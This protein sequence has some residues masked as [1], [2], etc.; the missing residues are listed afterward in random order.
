MALA[1]SVPGVS[2]GT[3][4]FILGFYEKFIESLRN[5]FVRHKGLRDEAFIYL[6]KLGIG[7]VIGFLSSVMVLSA[8]FEKNI[9]FMSSLFLGLSFAAIPFIIKAE[10]EMIV[11]KYWNL[12]FTLLGFL[13]VAGLSLLRESGTG[14]SYINF[15]DLN[16]GGMIY[17]FISG[18]VAITAMVLPG[19]SGSTLLLI[20]GVYMPMIKAISSIMKLDFGPLPGVLCV[21]FGIIAG[22]IFS[23]RLI[24]MAFRRFRVQCIYLILGLVAGSLIAIKYGP[25]T[26]EVPQPALCLE[27]FRLSAFIIGILLIFG[28]E[29]L[30]KLKSKLV[31]EKS[32]KPQK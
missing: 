15:W 7:W 1:D 11:G 31:K 20:F 13:L 28:V 29:M 5:I 19:I 21:G 30:P 2:G 6:G 12:V 8:L 27:T 16:V 32:S 17:L 24:R 3:V 18:L 14:V 4:A 23:V 26:M 9:Y 10:K 22:I 25:S